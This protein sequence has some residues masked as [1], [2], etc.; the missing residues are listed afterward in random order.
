[1]VE[2]PQ[3][4]MATICTPHSPVHPCPTVN[5]HMLLSEC[6]FLKPRATPR[7]SAEKP[8]EFANTPPPLQLTP[9][10]TP[11]QSTSHA[12]L[13]FHTFSPPTESTYCEPATISCTG[14]TEP[15]H[16]CLPLNWA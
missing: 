6:S 1:M 5:V 15:T 8:S 4:L 9:Q 11:I 12:S 2:K 14:G 7:L 3:N 16:P 13:F 10:A